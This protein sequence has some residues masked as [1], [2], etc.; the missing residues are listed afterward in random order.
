MYL[1]NS[2]IVMKRLKNVRTQRSCSKLG[3]DQVLLFEFLVS[4]TTFFPFQV[5]FFLFLVDGFVADN[6][7]VF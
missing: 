4:E 1:Q 2:A 6:T 5:L 3:Y 7:T